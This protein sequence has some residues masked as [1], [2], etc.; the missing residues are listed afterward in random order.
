MILIQNFFNKI[1]NSTNKELIDEINGSFLINIDDL[2]Y[3]FI[4]FTKNPIVLINENNKVYD[5]LINISKNDFISFI[6]K[7]ISF[8]ELFTQGK[9]GCEGNFAMLFKFKLLV[10]FE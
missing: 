9:L 3:Y 5:C 2:N 10:N 7:E 8:D 1:Q 6:S 4:D